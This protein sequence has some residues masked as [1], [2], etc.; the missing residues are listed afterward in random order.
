MR[1][2][3]LLVCLVGCTPA[4]SYVPVPNDKVDLHVIVRQSGAMI[5]DVWITESAPIRRS[6]GAGCWFYDANGCRT[7]VG[8]NAKIVNIRDEEDLKLYHEYHS[9]LEIFS[10]R[11]KFNV[12][13]RQYDVGPPSPPG[14]ELLPPMMP[15]WDPPK[16]GVQPPFKEPC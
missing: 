4:G 2:L 1:Y 16:T 11:Y 8:P 3:L 12:P 15:N 9:E 5:M 14:T 13:H 10:Y 7:G 6:A